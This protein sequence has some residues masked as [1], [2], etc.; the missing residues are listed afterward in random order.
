MSVPGSDVDRENPIRSIQ[1]GSG[2]SVDQ[3]VPNRNRAHEPSLLVSFGSR[4]DDQDHIRIERVHALDAEQP[5]PRRTD[6]GVYSVEGGYRRQPQL[7]GLGADTVRFPHLEPVVYGEFDRHVRVR[8]TIALDVHVRETQSEVPAL[9]GCIFGIDSAGRLGRSR[10]WHTIL[11]PGMS[12][13]RHH[14]TVQ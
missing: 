10:V 6:R 13:V 5:K 1:H 9:C 4:E 12:T 7:D 3:R 8:T 11:S 2:S 14:T